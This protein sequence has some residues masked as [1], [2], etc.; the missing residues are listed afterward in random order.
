MGDRGNSF[1]GVHRIAI[2][3]LQFSIDTS[4]ADFYTEPSGKLTDHRF[5]RL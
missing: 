4:A 3:S 1:A 5:P 2:F